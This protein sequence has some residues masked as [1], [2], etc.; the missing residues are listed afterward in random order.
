MKGKHS[1]GK[2]KTKHSYQDLYLFT[3]S[4]VSTRLC[5]DCLDYMKKVF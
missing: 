4:G 3:R 5:K 2:C 1:C